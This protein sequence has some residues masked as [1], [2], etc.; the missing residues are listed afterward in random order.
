[1]S[2]FKRIIIVIDELMLSRYKSLCGNTEMITRA[3][4]DIGSQTAVKN[5]AVCQLTVFFITLLQGCQYSKCTVH[6]WRTYNI[7][8]RL[9]RNRANLAVV[10]ILMLYDDNSG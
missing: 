6:T 5:A 1:L 3:I 4:H 2:I 9:Q 7:P 8:I 10:I